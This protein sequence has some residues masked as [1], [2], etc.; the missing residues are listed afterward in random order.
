VDE[1]LLNVELEPQGKARFGA[2]FSLPPQRVPNKLILRIP[3]STA[4]AQVVV[5]QLP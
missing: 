5:F 4:T 2:V 1:V 3:N